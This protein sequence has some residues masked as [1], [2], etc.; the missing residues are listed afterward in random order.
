MRLFPASFRQARESLTWASL[1][2]LTLT[3]PRNPQVRLFDVPSRTEAWHCA[4]RQALTAPGGV[5]SAVTRRRDHESK[6]GSRR[7]HRPLVRADLDLG[8][9]RWLSLLRLVEAPAWAAVFT[10]FCPF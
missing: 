5:P 1:P 4:A 10:H 9:N 2:A 8:G 3:N 6:A 7:Q